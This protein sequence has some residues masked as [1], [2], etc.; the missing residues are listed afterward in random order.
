MDLDLPEKMKRV[1]EIRRGSSVSAVSTKPKGGAT[2]EIPL[3]FCCAINGHLMKDPV[4]SPGG[5]VYE[6]DTIEVWLASRG[7]ICP[8]S[9]DVLVRD[10]LRDAEELRYKITAWNIK[11]T[12]VGNVVRNDAG[13]EEDVYDF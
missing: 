4:S 7:S 12:S 11:K 13:E 5:V 1:D 3:E 8:I 2:S 6:R 9:G 10:D